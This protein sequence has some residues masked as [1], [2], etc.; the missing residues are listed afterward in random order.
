MGLVSRGTRFTVAIDGFVS[1]I[2]GL[3][4]IDNKNA[5]ANETTYHGI[6]L[7]ARFERREVS[8][9]EPSI[10]HPERCDAAPCR[11]H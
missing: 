3:Q 11:L 5:S 2:S 4:L 6:E 8:L 7:L 9:L 1:T 10:C